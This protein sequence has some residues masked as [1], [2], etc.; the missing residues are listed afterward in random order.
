[1]R[2]ERGVSLMGL[3]FWLAILGFFGLL[4]AKLL[5]AYLEYFAVKK[6]FASMEQAG[7]TKGTVRDIRAAYDRRNAIEDVKSLRSDDLEITKEG[8]ETV[9]SAAW[10][11]KV[12]LIYNASACLD[13]A[14]TTAK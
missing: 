12:P 8:G 1:M 4:A 5:P 11:V 7:D 13:F 3:I 2:N 6:I 10:S 9:V 14:V